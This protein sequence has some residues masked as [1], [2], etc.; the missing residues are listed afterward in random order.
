MKLVYVVVFIIIL[1]LIKRYGFDFYV[2]VPR[3]ARKH[4]DYLIQNRKKIRFGSPE[5]GKQTLY[6]KIKKIVGGFKI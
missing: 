5:K 3:E 1:V 6:E 4:T 2:D